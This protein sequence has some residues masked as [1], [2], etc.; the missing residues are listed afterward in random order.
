MVWVDIF[1]CEHSKTDCLP[2]PEMICTGD[3]NFMPVFL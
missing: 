1:L 2:E 3:N